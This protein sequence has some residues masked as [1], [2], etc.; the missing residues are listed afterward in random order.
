MRLLSVIL[1]IFLILIIS[2]CVSNDWY[3]PTSLKISNIFERAENGI[4][5]E[6]KMKIYQKPYDAS[7]PSCI[8]HYGEALF[9]LQESDDRNYSLH[10][11]VMQIFPSLVDTC[12]QTT[13][14]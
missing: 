12:L 2:G 10:L 9:E 5:I 6:A 14:E 7:A 13:N 3:T 11:T 4:G 8:S 1:S